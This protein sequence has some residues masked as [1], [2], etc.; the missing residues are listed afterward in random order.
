MII[1]TATTSE[2]TQEAIDKA[3]EEGEILIVLN[4]ST[5]DK[6]LYLS[7]SGTTALE[8]NCFVILS[9]Y[10]RASACI[11][12][13]SSATAH[14]N[15]TVTAHNNA[16]VSAYNYSKVFAY[17]DSQV[18]AHDRTKVHAYHNTSLVLDGAG[19]ATLHDNASAVANGFTIRT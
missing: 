4:G 5:R 10:D 13:T 18:Y 2:E 1:I 14:D 8:A 15:S 9:L 16:T 12:N 11:F 17:N 19:Q 7:I 6:L 3:V